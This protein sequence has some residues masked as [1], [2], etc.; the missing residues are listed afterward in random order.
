MK[1]N[2]KKVAL[3]LAMAFLTAGTA[4]ATCTSNGY[5]YT[6]SGTDWQNKPYVLV[7]DS[8]GD[9]TRVR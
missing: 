4:G 7:C 1:R 3:M 2:L 9:C 5:G 6:C 8:A